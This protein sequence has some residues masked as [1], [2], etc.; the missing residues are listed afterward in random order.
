MWI[1]FLSYIL[2]IFEVVNAVPV[3]ITILKD[4][5]AKCLDG[6]PAGVYI[7]P[8]SSSAMTKKWILHLNGGGECDNKEACLSQTTNALGSS[9]YLPA[10]WD[11]HDWYLANDNC[12]ENPDFCQWNHVFFPY[13]TQ[14][15]HSGQVAEASNST[16]GLYFAGHLI[17][18]AALDLLDQ[19]PYNLS[20]ASEII[21]HGMSAGGIG[22]WMNV[23]YVADRYPKARVT[24]STIAGHYFY[25]TYYTGP[26]HTDPGTMADFRQEAWPT[27]YKLYNAFVDEDCRKAQEAKG[28]S[29]GACMLS[30]N[31]LS[32]IAS[33]AFVIQALT[34]QVVLTGHDNWPEAH[35]YDPPEQA[36]MQQWYEN[37]TVALQ[38]LLTDHNQSPKKS[39]LP[40]RRGVF[41]AACYTHGED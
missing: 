28:Q 20:H 25:A 39:F 40:A 4:P 13:C 19:P 2:L 29:P 37:M 10:Q 33:D 23:D 41:G 34:D 5:I 24:A 17:I 1:L 38:P 8:A 16:W 18:R 11:A 22:V 7:Q 31:S 12:S 14:D 35:M 6:S 32:Y 30:N 15:L 9:L 21:V 27:T 3:P 36:F 26:D